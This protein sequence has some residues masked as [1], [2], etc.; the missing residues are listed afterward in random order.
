MEMERRGRERERDIGAW[1]ADAEKVRLCR[2]G[3]EACKYSMCAG[4]CR[5]GCAQRVKL[6]TL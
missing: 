2:E 5:L 1:V 3:C 4:G 6:L